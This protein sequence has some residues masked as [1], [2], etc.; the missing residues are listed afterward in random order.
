MFLTPKVLPLWVLIV[1]TLTFYTLRANDPVNLT[2]Y[3]DKLYGVPLS[4]VCLLPLLPICVWGCYEVIRTVGP[5]GSSVAIEVY[6]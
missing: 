5:K 6:D 2:Q 3:Q 4:T 1:T